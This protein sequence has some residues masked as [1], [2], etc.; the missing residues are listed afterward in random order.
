[1]T[2]IA[3][4]LET[5]CN[6]CATLIDTQILCWLLYSN[7]STA[8]AAAAGQEERRHKVLP[9]LGLTLPGRLSGHQVSH[10]AMDRQ[11]KP[12]SCFAII[13]FCPIINSTPDVCSS[14][15]KQP[16]FILR[17]IKKS[18]ASS[19]KRGSFLL[20]GWIKC[21]SRLWRVRMLWMGFATLSL[22][23]KGRHLQTHCWRLFCFFNR[24]SWKV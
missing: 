14:R 21:D 9:A 23:G 24:I 6:V 8:A 16:L 17:F 18:L 20:R 11:I 4:P 3:A 1:M 7:P 2:Y 22:K 10:L 5:H 19:P 13:F 12:P 15:L